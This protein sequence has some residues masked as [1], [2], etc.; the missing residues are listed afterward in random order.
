[1]VNQ[2]FKLATS[3]TGHL[4]TLVLE[5]LNRIRLEHGDGCISNKLIDLDSGSKNARDDVK[6][7]K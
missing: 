7:H 5:K 1:M 3:S 6:R 4:A 2:L